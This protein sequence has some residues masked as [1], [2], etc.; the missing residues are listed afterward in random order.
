MKGREL[1]KILRLHVMP[2]MPGFEYVSRTLV[3]TPVDLVA[4]CILFDSSCYKTE[5][6]YVHAFVLPLFV[7]TNHWT[8]SFGDRLKPGWWTVRAGHEAEDTVR[9][10]DL[11]REQA[12]PILNL[13]RDL[14]TFVRNA[15]AF[16]GM[17]SEW[18]ARR[19]RAY[20]LILLVRC[21]EG[22]AV[23]SGLIAELESK[24][25]SDGDYEL[26]AQCQVLRDIAVN[27]PVEARTTLERWAGETAAN[28]KLKKFLAA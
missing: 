25:T 7:P 24:A 10:I 14:A 5:G 22:V 12:F 27:D 19:A 13:G 1:E 23:L 26:L 11:L 8:L 3:A 4:R 6:F 2:H 16:S 17:Q 28:L 20:G 15:D 18:H 21:F 9:L